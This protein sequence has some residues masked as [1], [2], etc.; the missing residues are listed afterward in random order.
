M[1]LSIFFD[2]NSTYCI[3]HFVLGYVSVMWHSVLNS[4]GDA[5][6]HPP[7]P[8]SLA[9]RYLSGRFEILCFQQS[10]STISSPELDNVSH[11]ATETPLG[12]KVSSSFDSL[13]EKELTSTT[14]FKILILIIPNKS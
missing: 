14:H 11:G 13:E 3:F 4:S 8:P 2:T 7:P 6:I 12:E 5:G 9:M 1:T 10:K